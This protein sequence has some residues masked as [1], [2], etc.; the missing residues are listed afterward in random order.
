MDAHECLL[1]DDRRRSEC[2]LLDDRRRSECLLLDDSE[3]MMSG[4][5]IA[6]YESFQK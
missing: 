5:S 3:G 1:L 6:M 4:S 2:L